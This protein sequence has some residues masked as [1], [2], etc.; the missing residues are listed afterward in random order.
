MPAL[1]GPKPP[2]RQPADCPRGWDERGVAAAYSRPTNTVLGSAVVLRT[3]HHKKVGLWVDANGCPAER[4]SLNVQDV[5]VRYDDVP[6]SDVT[7]INGIRCTTPLRTVI[8]LAP[9]LEMAEL[10]HMVRACLD[11]G[12][13]SPDEV[14]ERVARPDMLARPGAALLRQFVGGGA[15]S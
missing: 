6:E 10:K 12:L 1:T 9:E 14:M 15:A 3:C 7:S 4:V 8:D 2:V 13:F 5:I 11:R